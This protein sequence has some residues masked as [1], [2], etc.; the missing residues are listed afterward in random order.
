M[1][2]TVNEI[3]QAILAEKATQPTLNSLTTTVTDEQTLLTELTT[4]SKVAVWVLWAYIC[5]AAIAVHEQLWDV[6]QNTI[7]NIVANNTYGTLRWWRTQ[8]LLFQ[9][10]DAL[11]FVNDRPAY[12]PVD[13]DNRIITAA[14]AVEALGVV[15]LKAAKGEP[16]AYT[17]LSSP[18]I[19][20]VEEYIAQIVPA[21]VQWTLVSQAADELRLLATVY[22]DPQVISVSGTN[23]G[24]SIANPGTYPVEDAI[25]TYLA[26]LPFNG[27]FNLSHAKDAVQAVPGVRDFEPTLVQRKVSG[28]SFVGFTRTYQTAAGH[29][30]EATGAGNTFS[31]TFTYVSGY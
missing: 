29:M 5:A 16:G 21:G 11:T 6:F 4:T 31:D 12:D 22:V 3:F 9:Y 26:A 13:A 1:A 30:R 19:D 8:L 15:T 25:N 28:G 14:A 7:N 23:V 27:L 20:A 17:A 18:E 2:R 24:Q 10:G